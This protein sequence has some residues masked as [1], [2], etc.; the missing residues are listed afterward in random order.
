M[1]APAPDSDPPPPPQPRRSA[2]TWFKLLAVWFVG[3]IV[4]ARYLG[5]IAILVFQILS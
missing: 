4:W 3:L 2:S 1:P 5:L